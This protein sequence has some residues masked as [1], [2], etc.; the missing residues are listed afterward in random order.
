[1]EFLFDL[2]SG[3]TQA[4]GLGLYYDK[5]RNGW[6]ERIPKRLMPAPELPPATPVRLFE[7][8]H[9][10]NPVQDEMLVG[11]NFL[12]FDDFT[13]AVNAMGLHR[14]NASQT[15]STIFGGLRYKA[16]IVESAAGIRVPLT[17]EYY[18]WGRHERRDRREGVVVETQAVADMYDRSALTERQLKVV[19]FVLR[20]Y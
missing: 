18:Y 17:S 6:V 19:R 7:G 9:Y 16:E 3:Y 13:L 5:E 12:V 8:V 20:D 4:K 10:A 1:M 15:F 14:T 2:T 11:G